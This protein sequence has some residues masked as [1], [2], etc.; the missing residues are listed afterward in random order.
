M[1]NSES[2]SLAH[3]Q[4]NTL[5][6]QIACMDPQTSLLTYQSERFNDLSLERANI[7]NHTCYFSGIYMKRQGSQSSISKLWEIDS[8][9][10]VVRVTLLGR[11]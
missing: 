3:V 1:G 9:H 5:E 2:G 6:L 11:I 10:K 7:P 8:H 4:E